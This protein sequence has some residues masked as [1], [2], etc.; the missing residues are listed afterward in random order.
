MEAVQSYSNG[1]RVRI[2]Q[3]EFVPQFR[4]LLSDFFPCLDRAVNQPPGSYSM[5]FL[6]VNHQGDHYVRTKA[7]PAIAK[8]VDDSEDLVPPEVTPALFEIIYAHQAFR[9]KGSTAPILKVERG[10]ELVDRILLSP[11]YRTVPIVSRMLESILLVNQSVHPDTG[12][13]THPNQVAE[14]TTDILKR[15]VKVLWYIEYHCDEDHQ[16]I[17]RDGLELVGISEL[18]PGEKKMSFAAFQKLYSR[19]S[20]SKVEAA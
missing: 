8:S 10:L 1:L 13:Y 15:A 16:S 7:V 14:I 4:S 9:Q 20:P 19:R 6:F 18:G 11:S 3:G 12:V 2:C 17:P 5:F